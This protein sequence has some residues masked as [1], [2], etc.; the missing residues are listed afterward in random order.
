M[1]S[2]WAS[3]ASQ[4]SSAEV[5]LWEEMRGN[6]SSRLRQKRYHGA[7][8]SGLDLLSWLERPIQRLLGLQM[9]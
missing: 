6:T 9:H 5:T 7:R 4:S 1:L 2:C 3:T 8:H